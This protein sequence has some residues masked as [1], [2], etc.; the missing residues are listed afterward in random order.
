M[1][2]FLSTIFLYTLL[3]FLFAFTLEHTSF[4]P[5]FAIVDSSALIFFFFIHSLFHLAFFPSLLH[6]YTVVL[7]VTIGFTF[8]C[9]WDCV[10]REIG[11]RLVWH[12]A[13]LGRVWF[14]ILGGVGLTF[15]EALLAFGVGFLGDIVRVWGW[16]VGRHCSRLGLAFWETFSLSAKGMFCVS[17]I[18]ILCILGLLCVCSDCF[19]C[20]WNV[21]C[22][23]L[24][25]VYTWT[26]I[27]NTC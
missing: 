17:K 2:Y 16:H 7:A 10:L 8:R 5:L 26:Y 22:I 12:F 27:V 9:H 1:F 15:W 18:V 20:A 6:P 13:R 4:H 25:V 19:V 23:R 24:L 3:A 11:W 14:G 21:I